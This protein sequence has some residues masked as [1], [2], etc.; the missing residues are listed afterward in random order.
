MQNCQNEVRWIV[1]LILFFLERDLILDTMF[2]LIE[3]VITFTQ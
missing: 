1:A 2:A 3:I